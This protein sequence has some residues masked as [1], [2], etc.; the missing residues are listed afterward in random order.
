ME[1]LKREE[2]KD[3]GREKK[4]GLKGRT[5]KKKGGT[6]GKVDRVKRIDLCNPLFLTE[7]LTYD[8]VLISS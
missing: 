5:R 6:G 1:D 8:G 4:R 3:G 2:N 7:E